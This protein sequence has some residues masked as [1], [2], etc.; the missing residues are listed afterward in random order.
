MLSP[1]QARYACDSRR[2]VKA[3]LTLQSLFWLATLQ[4]RHAGINVQRCPENS[5]RITQNLPEKRILTR[6]H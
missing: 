5:F 3:A 4:M 2:A 6:G 1:S